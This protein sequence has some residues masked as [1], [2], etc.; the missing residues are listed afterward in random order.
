LITKE[1][2]RKS[3]LDKKRRK[4]EHTCA[5][6]EH[7]FD[8]IFPNGVGNLAMVYD[9]FMDDSA[10]RLAQKVIVSGIFIGDK[11]RWSYLRREWKKRLHADGMEYF[12]AAEYYGLRGQFQKFQSKS[13]YPEPQGRE[14]AKKIFDDLEAIIQRAQITSLGIVIPVVDYAEIRGLPEAH[15]IWPESPYLAALNSGFFETVKA[16]RK[17]AAANVVAFVHD[18][19]DRFPH[20]LTAYNEFKAKNPKTAKHMRGFVPLDDRDHPPLQA[21]DLAANVA[22]NF[23]KEW[24]ANPTEATLTRLRTSMYKIGVWNKEYMTAILKKQDRNHSRPTAAAH[25]V[26][27]LPSDRGS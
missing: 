9:A 4:S 12:K 1:H 27:F 11:E 22:C 13:Q 21:A 25:G 7:F 15:G 24:L 17:L 3:P 5:G 6:V 8:L 16:I 2:A 14:A 20:Y 19:D 10:D 18:N 26:M 23:A